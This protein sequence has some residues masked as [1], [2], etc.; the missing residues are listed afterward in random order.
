MGIGSGIGGSFGVVDESTY[1]TIVAPSRHYRVRKANI[2]RKQTAVQGGGLAAGQ[3]MQAGSQRVITSQSGEGGLEMDVFQTKMGLLF[4][5]IT[6]TA[7]TPVQQAATAAYLQTYPLVD[8]FGRMLTGQVNTPQRDGTNRAQTGA[9]GKITSA[10]FSCKAGEVLALN[11]EFDYQKHTDA[12]AYAAPSYPDASPPFHFAQM[13]VK[14]GAYNSEVAAAGVK[15]MSV[16]F[17]RPQDVDDAFYANNAGLKDQPVLNDFLNV[18]GTIDAD[19]VDKA[20]WVDRYNN[21]TPFSLVWEFV[22]DII[23]S[24]YRYTFRIT[25]PE[26][27]VDGET[28]GLEGPEVVSGSIP[29]VSTYNATNGLPVITYMSTDVTA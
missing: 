24:T 4:K 11:L 10:E 18:G 1:G 5:H 7:A 26:C 3:L 2:K 27:Y 9:G 6:G 13:G 15:G 23:A 8:N 17:E 16:K 20:L 12:Q 22:G 29:F 19:F 25:L 21:N 14:T 28:P